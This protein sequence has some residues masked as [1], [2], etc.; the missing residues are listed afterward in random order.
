MAFSSVKI[1]EAAWCISNHYVI[2][3]AMQ[4]Y[5]ITAFPLIDTAFQSVLWLYGKQHL[6]YWWNLTLH[7][8]LYTITWGFQLTFRNKS[9]LIRLANKRI[10]FIDKSLA[11][12]NVIRF[13]SSFFN[14]LYRLFRWISTV[15][16][17]SILNRDRRNE[18]FWII[19]YFE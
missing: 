1:G 4:Q 19:Q 6:K 18:L 9:I 5:H 3:H 11:F 15:D 17:S 8:N 12:F 16:Y 2:A 7:S 13:F 14:F 10:P